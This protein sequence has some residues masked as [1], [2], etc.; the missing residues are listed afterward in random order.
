[1]YFDIHP[2]VGKWYL[3]TTSCQ[4][5]EVIYV[6]GQSGVVDVQDEAGNVFEIDINAWSMFV[7]EPIQA[8]RNLYEELEDT[9]IFKMLAPLL[10]NKDAAA[11]V[12][13]KA[14][15][16]VVTAIAA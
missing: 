13:E 1:M 4:K 3:E 12:A 2:M 11:P 8:P 7:M 15:D 5:L 6:D 16:P 9:A 10:S 14:A